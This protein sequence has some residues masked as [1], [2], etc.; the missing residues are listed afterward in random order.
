MALAQ[1]KEQLDLP[2]LQ[3]SEPETLNLKSPFFTS[4][5]ITYIGNKRRLLPFLHREFIQIKNRIGKDRLTVMDGF[6]GS[7]AVSRLLKYFS[8]Y[9]YV[10]DFED[11]SETINSAYLANKSEVNI[12]ELGYWID[13]LNVNKLRS[14]RPGFIQKHYAPEEDDNIKPGERVFYT[15]KN[16]RIIDNLRN[17]IKRVPSQYRT[18]CLATLIVKASIHTN[19]SG[20]F[21]G[22]HKRNGNGHFG[23]KG[24]HALTR[25][26]KDIFL[27]IPELSDCECE[28]QVHKKDINTLVNNA[29]LPEFDLVYYDPPY[30]QHPYGSNYFMLNIINGGKPVEIQNGVSGIIKNWQKSVYNLRSEAE[31]FMDQLISNTRAKIIAISYNDEGIIPIDSLKQI[32]SKYGKW[33]LKYQPYNTYRGCRNLKGRSIK[34]NELLWVLEKS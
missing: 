22:F 32:M 14:K 19:T 17:L 15:S 4:H 2:M 1:L 7:G 27:E 13:W 33:K 5:L 8:D 30:N 10:N 18:F 3:S 9:L 20:V 12:E 11:Y 26:K 25:I 31:E 29:T 24:E 34:V 16:A 28:T 21:K 23:G 6:A